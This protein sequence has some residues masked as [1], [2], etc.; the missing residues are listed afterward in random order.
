MWQLEQQHPLVVPCAQERQGA[1]LDTEH[2][3]GSVA[4]FGGGGDLQRDTGFLQAGGQ[5]L[6][7]GGDAGEGVVVA[8]GMDVRGA[9]QVGDAL[10]DGHARQLQGRVEVGCPVVDA[11]Q[12][13]VVQVD[14]ERIPT[15]HGPGTGLGL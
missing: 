11:G 4:H 2:Q 5:Q 9:D 15:L 8:A 12:Q 14:H 3:F 1:L 10:L 13:V 7:G 6:P